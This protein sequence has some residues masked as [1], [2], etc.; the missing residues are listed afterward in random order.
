MLAGGGGVTALWHA[1]S[2]GDDAALP[3]LLA[4]A[5]GGDA[6]NSRFNGYTALMSAAQNG[7]V[8]FA[9]GGST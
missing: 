8:R 1:A 9:R 4:A 3:G 6:L 7:Q 5:K 2:R